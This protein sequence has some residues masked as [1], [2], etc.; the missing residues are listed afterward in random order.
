MKTF[1]VLFLLLAQ[2]YAFAQFSPGELSRAHASLEGSSNCTQCHE[3]GK[4]ISGKKCLACH[5][6]I[7]QQLDIKHGY[8][9]TISSEACVTCHKDHLGKESHT[10]KFD[11][12]SFDHAKTSFIL[13]DKHATTGCWGTRKSAR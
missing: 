10:F 8:H 6:E 3:V 11:N 4:E 1:L 12:K 5:T 7:Q 2:Q 13:T 9:F